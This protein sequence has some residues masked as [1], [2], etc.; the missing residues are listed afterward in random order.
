M[1][2]IILSYLLTI[3]CAY[4]CEISKSKFASLVGCDVENIAELNLT[5][6]GAELYHAQKVYIDQ[7]TIQILRVRNDSNQDSSIE[8]IYERYEKALNDLEEYWADFSRDVPSGSHLYLVVYRGIEKPF[9]GYYFIKD[10][11]IIRKDED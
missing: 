9:L 7:K 3:Y 4:A 10:G 8:L 11:A 2:I 5:S 1:K 6:V